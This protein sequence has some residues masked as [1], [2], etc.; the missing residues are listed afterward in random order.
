MRL[1]IIDDNEPFV[2]SL[3]RA[4]QDSYEVESIIPSSS[5]SIDDIA[6]EIETTNPGLI[7]IEMSIGK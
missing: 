5:T 7:F 4:L 3:M 2:Y 1:L 6:E